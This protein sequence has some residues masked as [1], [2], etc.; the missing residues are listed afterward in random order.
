ML[1]D[2]ASGERKRNFNI[3]KEKGLKRRARKKGKMLNFNRRFI[4]VKSQG[5]TLCQALICHLQLWA[6]C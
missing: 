2:V 5:R 6:L 3:N 4:E 1:T